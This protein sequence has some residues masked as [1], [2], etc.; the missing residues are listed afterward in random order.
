MFALLININTLKALT[1]EMRQMVLHHY[2][3]GITSMHKYIVHVPVTYLV[4]HPEWAYNYGEYYTA[5][6][7]M[8]NS[9]II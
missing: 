4:T 6:L 1:V 2:S 9:I 8:Y 7:F 3:K 5:H